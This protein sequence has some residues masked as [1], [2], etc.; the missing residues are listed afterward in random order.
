[1]KA[2]PLLL[3][4]CLL[5]ALAAGASSAAAPGSDT[6]AGRLILFW[7]ESPIPSLW[8]VRPDG[9]HRHRIRLRQNCKRPRLS[10]DRKWIVFDGTPPGEPPL[11]TFAIQLVRR[12]GTGRRI[13]T[14]GDNRDVD[15]QWSPDGTRISFSHLRWSEG[16]DWRNSWIW[17]IGPDGGDARPLARG[18]SARW[19]PDGKRLVF[20]APTAGGD[21]DLFVIDADGS[22][23]HPLLTT[24]PPEWPEDWSPDGKRILFTRSFN[25]RAADVYAIDA[26]G[27]HVRRLTRAPRND[28]GGAWSP[29]GSKIVFTSERQGRRHLFVMR[30]NGTRQH[31]ITHSGSGDW[32]PSW[33]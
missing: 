15:A 24:P 30:A 7:S 6:R 25:D 9:S 33:Y 13:L 3:L 23:L 17:T 21:G 16:D 18:N 22:N 5:V 11:T 31:A 4:A 14:R 10:P 27:T 26:D 2:R 1:V 32:D 29:D 19:S 12:D 8:T 20:S 28:S